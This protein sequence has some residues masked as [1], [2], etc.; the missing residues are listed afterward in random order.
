LCKIRR[1]SEPQISKNNSPQRI[2]ASVAILS[3]LSRM[4]YWKQQFFL[5]PFKKDM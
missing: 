1:P 3:A 4:S 5:L 2:H